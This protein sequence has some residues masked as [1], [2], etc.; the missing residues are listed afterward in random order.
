[1]LGATHSWAVRRLAVVLIVVPH[2]VE[3]VL[4]QL[5]DEAG[6]VAVL[7]VLRED[8]LCEFLVLDGGALATRRHCDAG[9]PKLARPTSRTTKL[10]PSFPHRTTFSS[11][12]F[13]SILRHQHQQTR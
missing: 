7:E 12:G 10:S 1:M 6:K 2:F 8:V 13:S 9:N 11:V 5:P 3:I 4:V